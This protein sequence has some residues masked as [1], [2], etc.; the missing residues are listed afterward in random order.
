MKILS[1]I[2]IISIVFFP[3]CF[4]DSYAD[5]TQMPFWIKNTAKW[6]SEGQV[7]DS[8]FIKG[9]QYL[10]DQK[11]IQFP[12][13]SQYALAQ[14]GIPVWV[15]NNAGWWANGTIT[16][17]DFI[18]GMQYLV[19]ENIIHIKSAQ[20]FE[21][22]STAFVND[23]AIPSKYTCDGD[24]ISPPLTISGTPQTAQS[25]VLTAVDVDAPNGPFTHWIM[26]NIPTNTTGFSAG[27]LI[28]YPQ[29][30]TS[31]GNLGYKGPCPPSGTH[32]Y[33]FTLYALDT[34]L[35]LDQNTTRDVLERS[36]AGHVVNQTVL[37]GTYSRG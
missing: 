5:S 29:G 31:A 37:M 27:E 19:Q 8:D 35:F 11:I 22:S 34:V 28:S 21:L 16:D 1:C 10:V 14:T 7:G 18:H 2:T 3:M 23:S 25:L 4:L 33:F 12:K 6:W 9:I 36:I 13:T 32:R 20:V 30:M 17:S 26:W 24:S 15:K